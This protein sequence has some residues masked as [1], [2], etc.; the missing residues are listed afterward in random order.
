MCGIFGQISAEPAAADCSLTMR[1]RGPDDSGFECLQACGTPYWI[2]LSQRRLAIIDLTPAGHQP[3]CNEDSGIWII[4]NGEIYNF[5]EL[6]LELIAAGHHFRSKTDTEVI[7]H[8]YE[9]WGEGVVGRLRGMFAFAIWDDRQTRMLLA[10]DRVG[11]KPLFY[12][13]DGQQLVFASEIKAI[14]A[15]GAVEA[16]AD[17]TSL[18][19]YLTYLYFPPPRTA[20]KNIFKLPPATCM[21]VDVLPGGGLQSRTWQY[22]DPVE[23]CAAVAEI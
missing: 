20:Y 23:C 3:M 11:K 16:E 14:L 5:Q 21:L 19:D 2:T 17:P 1:H 13:S 18:H 10:R 12:F 8:G 4:F 7:I 9:E 22:W 15:S 6:R